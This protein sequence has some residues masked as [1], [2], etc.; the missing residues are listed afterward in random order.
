MPYGILGH[1]P[2]CRSVI[3]TKSAIAPF[4]TRLSWPALPAVLLADLYLRDLVNFGRGSRASFEST[5]H[6]SFTC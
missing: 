6:Q 5:S 3:A 2:I 4:I 1:I